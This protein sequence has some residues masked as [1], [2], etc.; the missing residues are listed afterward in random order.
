M[1]EEV[2]SDDFFLENF[3]EVYEAIP[4]DDPDLDA[5]LFHYATLKFER[6]EK[7][8]S[9]EDL[10]DAISKIKQVKPTA[11]G[12]PDLAACL[13]NLSSMLQRRFER[14][15]NM[16]DLVEAV[17]KS[18]E[19]VKATPE[20]HPGLVGRLSNLGK[21]FETL[22]LTTGRESELHNA[23][24]KLKQAVASTPEGSP[25]LP[26][27]LANL[28]NMLQRRFMETGKMEDLED[29]IH[30]AE[31]AVV[32]TPKQHPDWAPFLNDL[33]SK[34][35][36][37]FTQTGR[38]EDLQ[39]AIYKQEQAVEATPEGH[40]NMAG[41]LSNLSAMLGTRYRQTGRT[42]D[43]EEAIRIGKKAVE[44]TPKGHWGLPIS[45]NT[46]G[47]RFQSL[48]ERTGRIEDLD[49]AIL[50]ARQAIEIVPESYPAFPSMLDNLANKLGY[51]FAQS[52]RIEDLEEAIRKSEQALKA[53]PE[54]HPELYAMLNNLCI[55]LKRKFQ[56]SDDIRDFE[57]AIRNSEHAIHAT[58]EGHPGL[59]TVL[60]HSGHLLRLSTEPIDSGRA[61]EA[62]LRSWECQNG[63]P[64]HRV[65]SAIRAVELLRKCG[66]WHQASVVAKQ[67]VEFLP[68]V[69]DRSLNREDLQ[70]I[71]SSFAGLAADACSLSLKV[72]GDPLQSIELLELGRGVILGYLIESR[73][74]LSN[75]MQSDPEKAAKY[76][77]LRTELNTPIREWDVHHDLAKRRMTVARELEAC[78]SDIRQLPGQERFLL[79]PIS[80]ELKSCAT[81]GPIV[82]VNIT[83]FRSDVIIVSKSVI[84]AVE[85]AGLTAPQV[86]SRVQKTRYEKDMNPEERGKK[87]KQYR[88]FLSWLWLNCVKPVFEVLESGEK[89]LPSDLSRIWWIGVGI[90]SFLPFHAAGDHS[91]GSTE[92]TFSWAISSYTPTIKALIYARERASEAT[93]F[94]R[95][96]PK[97]LII[98]MPTT[99]DATSL[100]GTDKEMLA[101]R[102]AVCSPFSVD[103]MIQPDV[104]EVLEEMKGYDMIHFACH[105]VSDVK[106]PSNSCLI[107]QH[108]E[109][110]RQS[111]RQ[112]RLT[113]RQVSEMNLKQARIAY[114]SACST[115]ENLSAT[116]LD[117]VIHLASGFQVA[118]F[119]HVIGSMW[120][121]NDSI[122]IEV[123]KGFYEGLKTSENSWDSSRAVA[124]ALH[125]S[126]NAVRPK[127]R[128]LPLRWAPFIHLGA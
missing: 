90:A 56:H 77:R 9:M 57:E 53:T 64:F 89:S 25:Y 49:E 96:Q 2:D 61:L 86:Q 75:L 20:G 44:I 26:G 117:E 28:S 11:D 93:K 43:L 109:E 17:R 42:E 71:I 105:G 111:L 67:A 95:N 80:E 119:C 35:R 94:N 112:D 8:G 97:L 124:L 106:N 102:D 78:I 54:G 69:N 84:K 24:S 16:E 32:A 85:L 65:D 121:S 98:T 126:I 58:P 23:I 46:L 127:A 12:D 120:P 81:E 108:G 103:T 107:L 45:L 3:D 51:R 15:G 68:I 92:N 52:G 41:H 30:G 88:E 4:Y 5:M 60:N 59:A 115:A 123:A 82:V 116:L 34:L 104:K 70:I 100:P 50:K 19:A 7:T 101:V 99:P 38:M 122:C 63:L 18:E 74:D 73:S 55:N 91:A 27:I 31:Q 83:D 48:F 21:K 62:F 10:D 87:N 118:G 36:L 1:E 66:N 39:E 6:Y 14:T 13:N 29:A 113:V 114:L 128:N 40:P 125:N 47:N 72:D 79:G 33:S 110:F 76:D 22:F 37:R